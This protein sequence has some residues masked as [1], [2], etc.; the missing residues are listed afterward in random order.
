MGKMKELSEQVAQ[1][2]RCCEI[3]IWISQILNEMF[4]DSY[5]EKPKNEEPKSELVKEEKKPL[6][7]KK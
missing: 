3:L 2:K 6:K 7:F 4:S 5:T 1:L